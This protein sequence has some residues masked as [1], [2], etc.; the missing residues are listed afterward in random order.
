MFS[1]LHRIAIPGII[2]H[3]CNHRR[4]SFV[5]VHSVFPA[6]LYRFQVYRESKL[7]DKSLG[8]DDWDPED[9]VEVSADGLVYPKIAVDG[10]V[11]P[12]SLLLYRER[13]SRFLLQPSRPM[14]LMDLNKT[15]TDFYIK[16]GTILDPDGWLEKH[17]YHEAYFDDSEEWMNK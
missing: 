13:D 16:S 11:I 15:L 14:S 17:P 3:S 5:S 4:F 7:F 1:G 12:D 2:R 9:S 10:T 8:K 6:A